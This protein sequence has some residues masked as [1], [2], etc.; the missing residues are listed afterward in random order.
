MSFGRDI[1][2]P[3]GGLALIAYG[4]DAV[5]DA[6]IFEL[7]SGVGRV[8]SGLVPTLNTWYNLC[9]TADGVN[10][11]FYVNGVLQNT[12]SQGSGV[13]TSTPVLSLGSYVNGSGT[14][15]TYFHNG[16]IASC[17]IYNRALTA[18]EVL[19]N[20]NATKSRFGR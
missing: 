19:Q 7:G 6:I 8:S 4:F 1:G 15:G 14:P 9:I 20:Y 10:T 2:L 12:A 16:Y 13:I 3:T 18:A 17:F 5:S 11:K